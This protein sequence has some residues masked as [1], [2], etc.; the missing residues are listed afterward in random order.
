MKITAGFPTGLPHW[1]EWLG[2]LENIVLFIVPAGMAGKST[3]LSQF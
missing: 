3:F 1:L 2:L